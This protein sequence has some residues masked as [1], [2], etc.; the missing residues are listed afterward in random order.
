MLAV[1]AHFRGAARG[2]ALNDEEFAARRIAFLAIGEFPGESTGI[3]GGFAARKFASF[4]RG[5]AGA[6][7]F[8]A[9]ADDAASDGGMLVKP[10]AKLFVHQ[11]LDVAFYIAVEFS[12]GLPFKL[13]LRQTHA[14]HRDQAFAHIVTVDGDFVLLFFQHSGGGGKIIYGAGERGA[15]S[16][17]M[18]APVHGVDGIGEGKNIFAI[19]IVVLQGDFD[20]YV[21]ALAFDVDWRIV[22]RGFAA[23]KM[24]YEFADAASETEI[25]SFFRAFIGEGDVQALV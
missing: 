25:G 16:G 1:P 22:Q 6:R 4:A 12:F 8:N 9:F 24:L 13:R 2:F 10:F 19:R 21:P 7:G 20:F 11:L 18:G 5:F 23:V 3:H 15:K 14:D 17:E